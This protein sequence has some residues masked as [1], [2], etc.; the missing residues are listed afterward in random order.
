MY[1][2][3]VGLTPELAHARVKVRVVTLGSL[4]WLR[5]AKGVKIFKSGSYEEGLWE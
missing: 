2:S 5:T 1:G 4:S 3:C